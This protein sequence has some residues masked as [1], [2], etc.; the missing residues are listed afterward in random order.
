MSSKKH[1]QKIERSF[2]TSL[3]GSRQ[4]MLYRRYAKRLRRKWLRKSSQYK[5]KQFQGWEDFFLDKPH[6]LLQVITNS[7]QKIYKTKSIYS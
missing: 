5:E 6:S 7:S 3:T 2:Y 4:T 1:I